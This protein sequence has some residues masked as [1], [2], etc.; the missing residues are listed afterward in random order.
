MTQE[1]LAVIKLKSII[2]TNQVA[3]ER[4][5]ETFRDLQR[6][7]NEPAIYADSIFSGV[8]LLTEMK[9]CVEHINHLQNEIHENEKAIFKHKIRY[10]EETEF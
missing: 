8:D 6:E 1:E 10:G 9:R 3:L 2:T 5:Q 4:T 7:A